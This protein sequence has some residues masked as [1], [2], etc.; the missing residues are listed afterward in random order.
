MIRVKNVYYMLSYAYHKL[1]HIGYNS[2][3]AEEFDNIQNLLATILLKAVNTQLKEGLTQEYEETHEVLGTVR[4]KIN[5]SESIKSN[6]LNRNRVMC[7]YEIYSVNNIFNQII[8]ATL[9]LLIHSRKVKSGIKKDLKKICMFFSDV[10]VCDL[11]KIDW[12]TLA[13]NR[14]SQSYKLI[15][16]ICYLI[17]KGLIISDTEGGMVLAEFLDEDQMH[18][19]YEKFILCYFKEEHPELHAKAKHIDWITD[20]GYI[21]FL[22]QM[23][24]DIV[25]SYKKRT[26]ILDA[27]YYSKSMRKSQ[28]G[29]KETMISSNLYQI[30][31]YVKN[32]DT[33]ED[34]TVSGM[35][36]YAKTDEDL[37]PNNQYSMSGNKIS[38][39]TL[40]L[41]GEWDVVRNQLED[42]AD[43]FI[44]GKI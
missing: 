3:S 6:V 30:F 22:P 28:Y 35:L 7:V 42:I 11:K 37:V 13:Y 5:I 29:K 43:R 15:M 38:I 18:S 19:L 31:T 12:N 1:S 4:G 10:S 23:R 26:L 34:G 2:L 41:N 25:L 39:E 44:E 8:K 9:L 27:K 33:E 36:L 21:E 17:S 16:N 20:D 24:T 40:D 14:N 32:Y